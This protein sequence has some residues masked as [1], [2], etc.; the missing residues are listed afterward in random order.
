M[1]EILRQ[2]LEFRVDHFL[3]CIIKYTVAMFSMLVC[4]QCMLACDIRHLFTVNC[5]DSHILF[6]SV[7]DVL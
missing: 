4:L 6:F 7:V 3:H 1:Q 5:I 2:K